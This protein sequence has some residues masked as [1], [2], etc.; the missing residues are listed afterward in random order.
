MYLP[1]A[2]ST[3]SAQVSASTYHVFLKTSV[4]ADSRVEA[5]KIQDEPGSSVVSESKEVLQDKQTK[6]DG[7]I[8]AETKEPAP[9]TPTAN[10]T[11]NVSNRTLS[12]PVSESPLLII[13]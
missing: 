12:C 10:A 5:G 8:M 7:A 11:N 6:R 9:K 1:V 2:S 4:M 3:P 13:H